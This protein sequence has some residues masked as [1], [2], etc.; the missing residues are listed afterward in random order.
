MEF[1]WFPLLPKGK[2]DLVRQLCMTSCMTLCRRNTMLKPLLMEPQRWGQYFTITQF[3]LIMNRRGKSHGRMSSRCL[4]HT[5]IFPSIYV[6]FNFS[7]WEWVIRQRPTLLNRLSMKRV[8]G[9]KTKMAL[10]CPRGERK[11]KK[12]TSSTKQTHPLV[13]PERYWLMT[14]IGEISDL[15]IFIQIAEE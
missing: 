4:Q 13:L 10:K 6:T 1:K 9:I 14:L 7:S 15:F 3:S 5:Q 2:C 11:A 8:F 12:R